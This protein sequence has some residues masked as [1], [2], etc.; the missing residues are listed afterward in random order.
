MGDKD[1]SNC[2]NTLTLRCGFKIDIPVMNSNDKMDL[3][4]V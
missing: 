4:I 3:Q 2:I 1:G